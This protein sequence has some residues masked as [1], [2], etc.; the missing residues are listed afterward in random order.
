[1]CIRLFVNG[2]RNYVLFFF[3]AL[4]G[5][6]LSGCGNRGIKNYGIS[7][8][9]QEI[10]ATDANNVQCYFSTLD[11]IKPYVHVFPTGVS[12][13]APNLDP[14]SFCMPEKMRDEFMN[15]LEMDR[16]ACPPL[17]LPNGKYEIIGEVEVNIVTKGRNTL[18]ARLLYDLPYAANETP[19]R[20]IGNVNWKRSYD[21]L[22][23]RAAEMGADAVLEVFGGE[24]VSSYWYPP[25]SS[26][27]PTFGS[28][29][30]IV[31]SYTQTSPGG[32]GLTGWTLQGL[33]VRWVD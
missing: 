5:I 9:T 27:V 33:A 28:G 1:M 3:V 29:G 30:Q 13:K 25:S 7:D 4:L 14:R 8:P 20:E 2:D 12:T 15:S 6:N 11:S 22:R 23:N 16:T 17:G 31:G 26:T 24:G 19:Y 18:R 21:I 32:I 10:Q